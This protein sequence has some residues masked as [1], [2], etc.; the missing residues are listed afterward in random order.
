MHYSYTP[1]AYCFYTFSDPEEELQSQVFNPSQKAY[2]QN[3]LAAEAEECLNL[4]YDPQNP[5][6]FAQ[7]DA[8]CKGKIVL[9]KRM[10]DN[11]NEAEVALRN[12]SN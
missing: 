10:L 2:I 8:E 7:Q 5:T 4:R 12:R 11:S 9:L 6:L 1:S 3:L